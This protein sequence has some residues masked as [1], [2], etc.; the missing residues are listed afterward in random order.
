MHF[1][2][3]QWTLLAQASLNGDP[4]AGKALE[5]F[6]LAYRGPVMAILRYRGEP[7]ERVEDLSQ[8]FFLHLLKHSSLRRADRTEGRFR[9]YLSAAL[10]HFLADDRKRNHAAK[11]GG[12]TTPLSLDAIGD[13]REELTVENNGGDLYLDRVWA[14]HMMKRALDATAREWSR[15]EKAARF[16]VLRAFLPGAAE[17]IS[18]QEAA[19]RLGIS[20]TALRT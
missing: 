18:Q 9:S 1:P 12:G 16:A 4:R 19:V 20:D 5:E 14:L 11:R 2:L 17:S 6:F 15:G 10:T 7:E 8:D 3:T 13:P